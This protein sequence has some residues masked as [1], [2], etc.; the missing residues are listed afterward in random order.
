[1][2]SQTARNAFGFFLSHPMLPA[3]GAR[4]LHCRHFTRFF[5]SILRLSP[6]YISSMALHLLRTVFRTAGRKPPSLPSRIG[7]CPFSLIFA[8]RNSPRGRPQTALDAPHRYRR[9][10]HHGFQP[11]DMGARHGGDAH[12]CVAGTCPHPW[13]RFYRGR[14]LRRRFLWR[15][16]R[17]GRCRVTTVKEMVNPLK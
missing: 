4:G 7:L 5:S 6:S 2:G 17:R 1:M 3:S 8:I 11:T 10:R 14:C 15:P 9:Y 13:S 16:Q 12:L